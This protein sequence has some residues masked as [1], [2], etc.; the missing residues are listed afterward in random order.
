MTDVY[1]IIKGMYEKAVQSGAKVTGFLG[2]HLE[3]YSKDELI[4][5]I[6]IMNRDKKGVEAELEESRKHDIL[7][8]PKRM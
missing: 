4:M 7:M 5:I 3:D 8:Y 1:Y 2:R 6:H